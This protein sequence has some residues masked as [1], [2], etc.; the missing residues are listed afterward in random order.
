MR[1][2]LLELYL[3]YG[4]RRFRGFISHDGVSFSCARKWE[5]I[6]FDSS[7]NPPYILTPKA[8]EYIKNDS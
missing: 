2:F 3:K 4:E 8:L 7:K 1:E 6:S 5:Y